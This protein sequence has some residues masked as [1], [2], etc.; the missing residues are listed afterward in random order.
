MRNLNQHVKSDK[1]K[2]IVTGVAILLILAILGGLIAAVVTETNPKEWFEQP[3][4]EQT[5]TPDVTDGDGNEMESGKVYAMP[6]S[7]VFATA[8]A[9]SGVKIKATITPSNA[10]NKNLEWS[11]VWVDAASSWANGK[12]V[13]DYISLTEE[14]E[15][16]VTVNCI[17]PFGQQAKI[18]VVSENNPEAKAECTLDYKQRIE[19]ISGFFADG[20]TEGEFYEF[21]EDFADAP[22]VAEYLNANPQIVAEWS[23]DLDGVAEGTEFGATVEKSSVYTIAQS[24]GLKI[25]MSLPGTG[26]DDSFIKNIRSALYVMGL[27][28]DYGEHFVKNAYLDLLD[29]NNELFSFEAM[30]LSFFGLDADAGKLNDYLGDIRAFYDAV[31]LGEYN[32]MSVIE[33]LGGIEEFMNTYFVRFVV[34]C[35][36]E[37][38]VYY[39][40]FNTELIQVLVESVSLDN[41]TL[42]F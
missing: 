8:A 38:K 39:S 25:E 3:G 15:D 27:N 35:A 23:M 7:M 17:K 41:G 1:V 10:T 33:A 40:V 5:E 12:T 30:M 9:E 18:V 21:S 4:E 11:V 32:I 26:M 6:S 20:Y 13:T 31:L 22:M 42:V 24:D 34:T 14:S 28:E 19:G 2:W 29:V 16:V 37:Q 36:S